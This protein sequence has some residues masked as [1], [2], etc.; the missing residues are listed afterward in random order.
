VQ[1]VAASQ[2]DT[3]GA[4]G[5]IVHAA[6]F[7]NK[8]NAIAAKNYLSDVAETQIQILSGQ[9][10]PIYRVQVGPFTS[11]SKA[12]DALTKVKDGGFD[13]ARVREINVQQVAAAPQP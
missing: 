6:S 8:A 11:L 9:N 4:A 10:G 3:I 12:Q 2:D 5:Y 7:A 13:D 1:Q